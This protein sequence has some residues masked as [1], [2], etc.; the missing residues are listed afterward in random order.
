M[1]YV[2]ISWLAPISGAQFNPVVTLALAWRGDVERRLILP[3]ISA[4][5][6][7]AVAGTALAHLMFTLP[8]FTPSL[9]ARTGASQWLSEM[10]AT[11]GLVSIIWSAS[12]A[13]PRV[14][15]ALVGAYIGAAYWFTAS[16]SF[17]NPAVTIARALTDSFSGIRPLDVPAFIA[18]QSA[19]ALLAVAF[20]AWLQR[21]GS[22]S[23]P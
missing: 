23:L 17:A 22:R 3:T 7:G 8:L 13:N 5:I 16:T 20:G 19:G 1:L 9:H 10:V 2:L 18:A 4:Q 12:I 21:A 6:A 15:P 11:F 14:L